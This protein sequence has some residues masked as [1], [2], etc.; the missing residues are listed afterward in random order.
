VK[1]PLGADLTLLA[2]PIGNSAGQATDGGSG[3][4]GKRGDD[5]GV[6]RCSPQQLPEVMAT[7]PPSCYDPDDRGPSE[8]NRELRCPD[9]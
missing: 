6:H 5:G 7:K 2:Q 3:E 9:R 1:Q 4:G 8:I